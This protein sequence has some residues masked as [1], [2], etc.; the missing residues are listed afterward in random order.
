MEHQA[1][2]A[3]ERR[4]RRPVRPGMKAA[5]TEPTPAPTAA[6]LVDEEMLQ[7]DPLALIRR[8]VAVMKKLK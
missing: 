7:Q 5:A 6:G 3:R 2:M 1:Q 4:N 8:E